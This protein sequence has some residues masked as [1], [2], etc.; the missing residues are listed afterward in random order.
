VTKGPVLILGG[1]SDI[2][3]AVAHRFASAGHPIQLA[4]RNVDTLANDKSDIELRYAVTVSL[5]EFDILKTKSHEAFVDLLDQLP[6]IVVCT[7]GLLGD[8]AT[9]ERDSEAASLV[10]RS[11]FEGPALILGVLANRFEELRRGTIVGIS[12]VA[13]DRGRAANYIY[14][15]SKAGF[16][17]FLSGLRNRL[18]RKGVHVVTVKPGFVATQMV[19][20]MNLP[21]WLTAEPKEPADAIFHAVSQKSNVVYVRPIWAIVM[22][23]I[24]SIPE[25]L[26]KKWF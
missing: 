4:A 10:M 26:F 15:S 16:T 24:R 8:Q 7:V 21:A 13:G 12:S 2:G 9:S 18:S 17:A 20:G 19:R 25:Y 23:I 3:L 1:R 22:M 11:N 6:D 5:Y 14:G